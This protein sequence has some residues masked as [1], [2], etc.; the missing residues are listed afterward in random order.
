[1][2]SSPIHFVSMK[3][4]WIFFRKNSIRIN[5]KLNRVEKIVNLRLWWVFNIFPKLLKCFDPNSWLKKYHNLLAFP[6]SI[7]RELN[8]VYWCRRYKYINVPYLCFFTY[9]SLIVNIK[10]PIK[11]VVI[12]KY[13]MTFQLLNWSIIKFQD[14][15]LSV[16]FHLC[17]I[18]YFPS[19]LFTTLHLIQIRYHFTDKYFL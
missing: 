1:M 4:S 6:D 16:D 8:I 11:E 5:V 2:T 18:C 14:K 3:I 19:L 13:T 15:N 9:Y 7:Q 12:I 10:Y 17:Y